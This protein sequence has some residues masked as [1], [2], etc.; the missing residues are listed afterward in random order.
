M[1]SIFLLAAV[2]AQE[3]FDRLKFHGAPKALVK[4][5]R[6]GDWPRV[7][8]PSDDASTPEGP[9]LRD[10]P[11]GGPKLVWEVTVGEGYA[12]P[13]ISGD[14]CVIFHAFNGKETAECLERE[15]GKRLWIF[16]Y[17]VEYQ[18]R[19]GFGGGPRGSPVIADGVVV[20]PG[21][22]SMLH[23]LDLKTGKVLW[24]HDLRAEY[25][26]P[27]DF[28]GAGSTPLILDGKVIVQVGGKAEAFD[29]FE[30]RNERA[31]K[32]A[33]KGV[34]VAA[35]D[36]KTGKALWTVED[37]WGASY[38]SPIPAKLHGQT[39]VLIYAGGESDPAAGGLLC[40]DPATGNVHDRFPWRDEE[41]IQATGSSPVVIPEENRVFISTVYP[42]NKPL[43]G[44]M[45]E[46]DAEFKAK[47]VWASKKLA[48]HWMTPIYQDGHLYAIDGERENNS[49]LVCVN[50]ATGAEVWTKNLEWEDK[51][52][53]AAQ[54]R[55][56]PV[57]L[58]ILRASLLKADGAVLCLG[59]TGS[60]HWLKLSP[61]GCEETTRAQLFYALNTWSLPAVSHGLLYISQHAESLDRKSAPRVLCYDLRGTP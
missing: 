9:L 33:T 4:E 12:A 28:F 60:L 26:V 51:E 58:S 35:F 25:H 31:R 15:T 7:L 37:A 47:Q 8:G 10:W 36:L 52:F 40:L 41:Y 46:Y 13:A 50:A 34:S 45:V 29:G 27:Q 14:F 59:E 1:I 49:R 48:C 19:Y 23:A 2:G 32:L 11:P 57:K 39:K 54:G 38:A 5:A 3:T 42:K 44:V 53:G 18:D 21:V 16:D 22:T 30:D 24:K 6:V 20:V 43:G 61:E 55:S 17:P 56:R